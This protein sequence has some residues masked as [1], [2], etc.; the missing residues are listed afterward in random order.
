MESSEELRTQLLQRDVPLSELASSL[1]VSLREALVGAFALYLEP[2][3]DVHRRALEAS[4]PVRLVPAYARYVSAL[5]L[6]V[7]DQ[8]G[9]CDGLPG[10]ASEALERDAWVAEESWV[11]GFGERDATLADVVGAVRTNVHH[12]DKD[13]TK[14]KRDLAWPAVS[15]VVPFGTV[16]CVHLRYWHV[17]IPG[18]ALAH[19]R[20]P[21][22]LTVEDLK[23]HLSKA[24]VVVTPP[25]EGGVWTESGVETLHSVDVSVGPRSQQPAPV[26][27][28]DDLRTERLLARLVERYTG[29]YSVV[30]VCPERTLGT[31][32][33]AAA[34]L[35][36]LL[37]LAGSVVGEERASHEWCVRLPWNRDHV[38]V[39]VNP[40]YFRTRGPFVAAFPVDRGINA[41]GGFAAHW[42][43]LYCF[44]IFL[45]YQEKK[46]PPRAPFHG[47]PHRVLERYEEVTGADV[48]DAERWEGSRDHRHGPAASLATVP[49]LELKRKDE[50]SLREGLERLREALTSLTGLAEEARENDAWGTSPEPL[51]ADGLV[52]A[53]LDLLG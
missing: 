41:Q 23:E 3:L 4:G 29:V 8:L 42:H 39:R 7:A 35:P 52:D 24:D 48:W 6:A 26:L 37:L 31:T 5:A 16:M 20:S 13:F 2:D 45:G 47:F 30:R 34:V 40:Q 14:S 49:D 25:G 51:D 21:E 32:P 28:R 22:R 1:D 44:S 50:E 19:V 46:A 9:L 15:L 53:A 10:E 18:D 38:A 27:S 12:W 33:R 11:F 43:W 36:G 17:K